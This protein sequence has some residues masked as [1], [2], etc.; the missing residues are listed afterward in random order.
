MQ[1]LESIVETN[2]P[3]GAF[4]NATPLIHR[5]PWSVSS[6]ITVSIDSPDSPGRYHID[7]TVPCMPGRNREFATLDIDG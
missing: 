2:E 7:F 4:K 6:I 1:K 3:A 5:H